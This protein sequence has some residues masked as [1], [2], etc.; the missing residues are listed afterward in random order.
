MNPSTDCPRFDSCS[1][2]LCPMSE[3]S[4][5][6]CAWFP[7]EEVCK[8]AQY[9]GAVMATRQR[10]I[11]KVTRRDPGRGCFTAAMLR[12]PCVVKPGIQGLDPETPI[13]EERERAWI[14]GRASTKTTPRGA[15]FRGRQRAE[16][17]A[18]V[19]LGREVVL[20]HVQAPEGPETAA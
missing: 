15:G 18:P 6:D 4:Q 2:P 1:A 14:A 8:L 17:A 10:R 12:H 13:T 7:D 5:R 3:E 20:A 19:V 16:V 9:A 11:A